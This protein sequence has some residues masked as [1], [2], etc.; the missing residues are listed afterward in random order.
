[1]SEGT[2]QPQPSPEQL[3]RHE[4]YAEQ[5]RQYG[6]AMQ[7]AA[8]DA[9]SNLETSYVDAVVAGTEADHQ[10]HTPDVQALRADQSANSIAADGAAAEVARLEARIGSGLLRSEEAKAARADLKDWKRIQRDYSEMHAD[11]LRDLIGAEAEHQVNQRMDEIDPFDFYGTDEQ[12]KNLEKAEAAKYREQLFTTPEDDLSPNEKLD[13]LRIL[14]DRARAAKMTGDEDG[15]LAR[16]EEASQLF[17]KVA[18]EQGW[19]KDPALRKWHWEQSRNYMNHTDVEPKVDPTLEAKKNNGDEL[20]AKLTV[21]EEE[22]IQAEEKHGKNSPEYKKA[23]EEILPIKIKLHARETHK[24]SKVWEDFAKERPS[25]RKAPGRSPEGDALI[26][27]KA[28][29]DVAVHRQAAYEALQALIDLR[30]E[31][32]NWSDKLRGKRV[33][34]LV[35]ALEGFIKNGLPE[36]IKAPKT[37]DK[38]DDNSKNYRGPFKAR[39][40]ARADRKAKSPQTPAQATKPKKT[41]L[42]KKTPDGDDGDP[43]AEKPKN[44]LERARARLRRNAG[45]LALVGVLGLGLAGS[46]NAAADRGTDALPERVDGDNINLTLAGNVPEWADNHEGD[47]KTF[48]LE[49]LSE[50]DGVNRLGEIQAIRNEHLDFNDFQVQE[51]LDRQAAQDANA[52]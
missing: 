10:L 11:D 39:R 42:D 34:E 1:M 6:E 17:N 21:A 8:V 36:D 49:G 31:K 27:K 50:L 15:A 40:A 48:H 38:P 25:A 2:P 43:N 28:Y 44:R 13:K 52:A 45:N 3:Q 4:A 26:G 20:Q 47:Y 7:L 19:N 29:E 5:M 12:K 18:E 51:M 16:R 35:A 30:G 37:T 32:Y 23:L 14:E 41:V 33:D 22:L 24:A 9:A 46:A